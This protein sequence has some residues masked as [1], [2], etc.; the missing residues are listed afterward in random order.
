MMKETNGPQ[1]SSACAWYDRATSSWRTY[2]GSL[3]ADIL[4]PFS[5]TWPKAG[6]TVDG[7]FYPQPSWERP[8]SES[9]SGLWPT[10]RS[11]SFDKSHAPGL[12]ALDVRVRGLY[13]EKGRY[14][15]TPNATDHKGPSA[16]S[17]GKERPEYDDDLPTRVMKWPTPT[18]MDTSG[19]CGK[20]DVGRTSPNSGRTLSGKVLEMEGRG[21]HA[22]KWPTPQARD[23]TPRGAQGKRFLNPDRSNDLPD[24][25]AASQTVGGTLNPTWVEWLMGWPLGW[26][27]C[28]PL[29]TARYRRWWRQHG[30]C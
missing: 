12:T 6:M 7:A 30:G 13:P 19:K 20:P 8:I 25:V 24:A 14:W 10:P 9:E 23:G 18:V 11:Y 17:P 27:D 29:E 5:A 15:P 1:Q 22:Q 21:P 2:Q 28:G 3:L 26:T 4:E 16:R